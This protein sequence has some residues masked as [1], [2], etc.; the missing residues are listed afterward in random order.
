MKSIITTNKI[1]KSLI[2]IPLFLTTL[3]LAEPIKVSKDEFGTIRNLKVYKF[4]RWIV[5]ITTSKDFLI[6]TIGSYLS[7]KIGSLRKIP[8]S[9]LPACRPVS[10]RLSGTSLSTICIPIF[11]ERAAL[12]SRNK[13]ISEFFSSID[14]P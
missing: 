2:L 4:P 12:I 11:T 9:Y 14:I 5:Q 13:P 7:S 6:S 8:Q 1:I 3:V 10:I